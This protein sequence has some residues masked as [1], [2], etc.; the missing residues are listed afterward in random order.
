MR[1]GNERDL[2]VI[3]S[4]RLFSDS[5]RR[6]LTRGRQPT[7]RPNDKSCPDESVDRA[8]LAFRLLRTSSQHGIHQ[9]EAFMS[10]FRNELERSRRSERPFSLSRFALVDARDETDSVAQS[11]SQ[12]VRSIDVVGAIDTE[13][14]VLWPETPSQIAGAVVEQLIGRSEQLI[15]PVRTITFPDDGLTRSSL[16]RSLFGVRSAASPGPV[17]RRDGPTDL[18]AV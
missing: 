15:R 14:V 11:I 2:G 10:A 6:P 12:H 16:V 4:Y 18:T 17:A 5:L 9:H 8:R 1:V 3:D 7:A 13:I